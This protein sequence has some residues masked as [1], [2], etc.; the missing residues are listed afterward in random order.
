MYISKLYINICTLHL[1]DVSN[2]SS[3]YLC[4]VRRQTSITVIEFG[5]RSVLSDLKTAH[6]VSQ[7]SACAK[8]AEG[9]WRMRRSTILRGVRSR[10][11]ARTGFFGTRTGPKSRDVSSNVKFLMRHKSIG[12]Y[13]RSYIVSICGLE[14]IYLHDFYNIMQI[15]IY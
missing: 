6:H 10:L 12:L 3:M 14:Q 9:L 2:V 8:V 4:S 7:P 5:S 11:P 13:F 1:N 15:Y